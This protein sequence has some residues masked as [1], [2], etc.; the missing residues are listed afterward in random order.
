MKHTTEIHGFLVNYGSVLSSSQRKLTCKQTNKNFAFV[1]LESLCLLSTTTWSED[2][3]YMEPEVPVMF[4]EVHSDM[5]GGK[6]LKSWHEE[7]W[8]DSSKKICT[9]RVIKYWKTSREV[10]Q[11]VVGR[12]QASSINWMLPWPNWSNQ[13]CFELGIRLDDL[14]EVP[15]DIKYNS[16]TKIDKI[17]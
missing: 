6:G 5:T 15:S 16:M 7:F 13:A 4:S 17:N 9:M 11:F 10:V 8:L 12:V 14:W 1:T 3:V 2:T